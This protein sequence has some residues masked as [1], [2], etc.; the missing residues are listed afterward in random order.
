MELALASANGDSTVKL[1]TLNGNLSNKTLQGH[2]KAVLDVSFSP[3]GKTIA[4]ASADETVRLWNLEDGTSQVFPHQAQVNR[5]AFS[6]SGQVLASASEDKTIKFWNLDGKLLQDLRGFNTSIVNLGFSGDYNTLAAADNR[7]Q[8]M[9]Q[10]LN[11]DNLLKI[12]C[13][14]LGDYLNSRPLN[15]QENLCTKRAPSLFQDK[16][17]TS[18]RL[19][20]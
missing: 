15:S 16:K 18:S 2:K 9:L 8:V 19:K 6:P 1:W 12:S 13:N 5:V 17:P 10:N 20:Y 3:D 11:L 4:S 7:G 14:L